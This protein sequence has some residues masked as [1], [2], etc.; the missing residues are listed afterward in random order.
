M[1][2]NLGFEASRKIEKF[3]WRCL[4]NAIPCLCVLANRHIGNVSQ[5][6]VCAEG[7]EDIKHALFIC[8]RARAV[9]T[10]LGIWHIILGGF[11]VDRGE[12]GVLEFLRC[13][14]SSQQTYNGLVEL[15][16]L[17]TIASWFIWWQRR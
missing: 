1:E 7:A 9:W 12:P 8:S 6:P 13:D 10:A 16:E 17:I 3:L 15:P 2:E 11:L 14:H 5:C 4:H